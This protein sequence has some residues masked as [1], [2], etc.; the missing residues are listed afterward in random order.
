MFVTWA[1]CG[2]DHHLVTPVDVAGLRRI[3]AAAMA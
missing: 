3:T 2:F 1:T